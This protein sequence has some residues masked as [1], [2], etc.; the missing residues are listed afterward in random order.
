[1][2]L[3]SAPIPRMRIVAAVVTTLLA[4]AACKGDGT[5]SSP[6]PTPPPPPP[7]VIPTAT[8]QVIRSAG[9]MG[10]PD[11]GTVRVDSGTVV[12][13]SFSL[14]AGYQNLQVYVDSLAAPASGSV[15]TAS[16]SHVLR[17]VALPTPAASTTPEATAIQ[18]V[19]AGSNPAQAFGSLVSMVRAAHERGDTTTL[20]RLRQAEYAALLQGGPAA[21]ERAR[22]ALAG[23][24]FV[25]FGETSSEAAA[26]NLVS[27][28]TR[29]PAESGAAL[30]QGTDWGARVL[31]APDTVV[32]TTVI[33]VNGIL[34]FTASGAHGSADA[35]LQALS[36]AGFDVGDATH[37]DTDGAR[38]ASAVRVLFHFNPFLELQSPL[39]CLRALDWAASTASDA[40]DG[41]DDDVWAARVRALLEGV[42]RA[43]QAAECAFPW[44]SNGR[45]M[46]QYVQSLAGGL[47]TLDASDADLVS[48]IG[49]ERGVA[50]GRNVIVLG[51]SQGTLI[52]RGAIGAAGAP[53]ADHGC[54]G[55]WRSRRRW[56]RARRGP[57]PRHSIA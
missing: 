17:A 6:P 25:L 27:A 32:P 30:R 14:A 2:S 51:H 36:A 26:N 42:Q 16:G 20:K 56:A 29:P 49:Q 41:Q 39:K 34:N 43:G 35:V 46:D 18:Q 53:T 54:L 23:R 45:V 55:G 21:A 22:T 12:A 57:T 9:V 44:S 40:E 7:P 48:V 10:S 31:F 11:T 15:S 13:Y 50:G 47:A 52:A 19:Y 4:L 28:S 5:G 1:M 33:Y 38:P 3:A 37:R 24:T 8:V